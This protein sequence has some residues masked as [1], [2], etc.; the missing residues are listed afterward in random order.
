M[1]IRANFSMWQTMKRD[2]YKPVTP[3]P[4]QRIPAL[5]LSAEDIRRESMQLFYGQC[6]HDGMGED[7]A[8]AATIEHFAI[9]DHREQES[10]S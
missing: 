4:V 6:I 9:A 5:D 3:R 7:E 2:A 1:S 10:Q 8:H